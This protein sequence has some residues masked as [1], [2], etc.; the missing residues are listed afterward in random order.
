MSFPD[1]PLALQL[2]ESSPDEYLPETL[3]GWMAPACQLL[4]EQPATWRAALA[5]HEALLLQSEHPSVAVVVYVG[6]VDALTRTTWA[7]DKFG[8]LGAEGPRGRVRSLLASAIGTDGAG[9]LIELIYDTR[10]DTSHEGQLFGYEESQGAMSAL[11]LKSMN[12]AG[13]ARFILEPEPGDQVH[14]FLQK[15]LSP[16]ARAAR[17]LLLRALDGE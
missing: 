10:N 16:L 12:V 11:T 4:N 17:L 6:A 9:D 3:P 8:P 14:A 15:V 1:R 5:W 2:I 13:E 7:V